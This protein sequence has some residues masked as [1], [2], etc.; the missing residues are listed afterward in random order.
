MNILITGGAGYIGSVIVERWVKTHKVVVYDDLATGRPFLVN[1][2]A[3]FI[4]GSILDKK[5]LQS[6]FE[7]YQFDIVFHFA[8]KTIVPESVV[9]PKLYFE[10]NYQGTKNILELMNKYGCKKLIFASSAAVYG[11]VKKK[12][13]KEDDKK[14]P[15]NPYGASKLLAEEAIISNKKINY[16]IFRFFNV[17]GASNSLKCGMQKNDPTL[18]IPKLNKT[19]AKGEVPII[20]GN[21]Y[22]TKDKTCIRDYVH[23]EDIANAFV[24]AVKYIN[25]NKVGVFNLGSN[26]GYSVLQVVEKAYKINGCKPN[27]KFMPP[28]KGDP[29]VLIASNQRAKNELKWSPRHSLTSMIKSDFEFRKIHKLNDN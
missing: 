23:V 2:K 24:L 15:C 25:K 19:I 18:L 16:V 14:N 7:K 1:D 10:T 22:K 3:I 13:I 27:Y 5:K 4:Q 12:V 11:D 28:R 17:A 6:V 20:F 29:A 21:R 9:K 8:A 26:S